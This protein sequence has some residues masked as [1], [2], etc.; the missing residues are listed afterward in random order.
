MKN[1]ICPD[2]DGAGYVQIMSGK[3]QKCLLCNGNGEVNA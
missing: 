2:C 1:D 3:Y